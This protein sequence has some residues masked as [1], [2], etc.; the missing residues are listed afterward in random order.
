MF[1]LRLSGLPGWLAARGVHLMQVPG[2]SRRLGVVGDWMLSL[3]F[4][5]NIVTLSGLDALSIAPSAAQPLAEA[6]RLPPP[7]HPGPTG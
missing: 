1:G 3:L 7:R 4:P 2:A 6:V 5:G